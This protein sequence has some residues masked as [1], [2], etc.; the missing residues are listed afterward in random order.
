VL[1]EYSEAEP[2]LTDDFIEL[3]DALEDALPDVRVEGNIPP[4]G[5]P[6]QG[7]FEVRTGGIM[8][9]SRLG[10]GEM[11]RHIALVKRLQ[12]ILAEEAD[13]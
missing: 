6:R 12:D 2:D 1:V 10:T 3:A 8:L 13:E 11:P 7:A 4:I 5:E 9:H